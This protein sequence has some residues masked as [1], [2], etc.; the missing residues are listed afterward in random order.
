MFDL[1]VRYGVGGDKFE[2]FRRDVLAAFPFPTDLGRFV[3]EALVWNRISRRYRHRWIDRPVAVKEY[4]PGGL[5]ER[6]ARVR[7]ES[8]PA[9]RLFY[10]EAAAMG[11]GLP[12]PYL[13]RSYV[14]YGRFSLHGG[15][16]PRRIAADAPAAAWA[17]ATLPLAAAL[18][19]RDRAGG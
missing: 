17:L 11:P 2:V 16:G 9:A 15:F 12:L 10:L 8:W 4:R 1:R 3:T 5:T 14:N 13:L 18:W 7:A 19:L 6:S